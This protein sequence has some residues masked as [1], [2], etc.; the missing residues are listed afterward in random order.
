MMSPLPV[1]CNLHADMAFHEKNN[2]SKLEQLEEQ[3]GCSINLLVKA[4]KEKFQILIIRVRL[5]H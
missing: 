4:R 3:I 5:Y 2:L 1:Q